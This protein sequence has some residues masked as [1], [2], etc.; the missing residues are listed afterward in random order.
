MKLYCISGLG[1]D[2]RVFDRL[3]VHAELTHLDWIEPLPDEPL[4]AYAMRLATDI[5][6]DEPYAIAGLSFGGLI[7]T[8]IA[9]RLNPVATILISSAATKAELPSI[10]RLFGGTGIPKVMP[11]FMFD[12][13]SGF[14][15]FLFGTDEKEMLDAILEDTDHGFVKWAITE[16]TTWQNDTV[17]E[18]VFRIHGDHDK[19]IPAPAGQ[20]YDL[21]KDGGHFAIVDRAEA[22]STAINRILSSN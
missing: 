12:L 15:A 19:V 9:H 11:E 13:P 6:Q 8:E 16:L 4:T 21:I 7:A 10:Y 1:A 14:A 3:S 22:V 18:R 2:R 17:P 5:D 20:E